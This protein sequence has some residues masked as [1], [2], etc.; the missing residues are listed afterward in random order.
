MLK[1]I[2]IRNYL[3]ST[4]PPGTKSS[5]LNSQTQKVNTTMTTR[6]SRNQST[7]RSVFSSNKI[8]SN[9]QQ[10]NCRKEEFLKIGPHFSTE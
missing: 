5:S 1:M 7:R 3:N 9:K 10:Q 4:R 2:V 8:Y 6:H